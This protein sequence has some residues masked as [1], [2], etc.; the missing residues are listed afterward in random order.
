MLRLARQ[1]F[2]AYVPM[3]MREHYASRGRKV[4]IVNE[5]EPVFPGYILVNFTLED[6]SWKSINSTRGVIR[7]IGNVE[8]GI[9]IPLPVGEIE[10]LQ[11]RENEGLLRV[12]EIKRIRQGDKIR[13]EVGYLAGRIGVVSWTK[14]DRVAFLL[15]LLGRQSVVTAPSHA[16]SLVP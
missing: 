10:D 2:S 16:L 7:L 15:N 11:A 4:V 8:T 5:S 1:G 13:V 9:P 3:Q 14:G 12:S 6:E